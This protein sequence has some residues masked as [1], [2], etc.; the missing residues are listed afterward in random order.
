M[1]QQAETLIDNY[2]S[3]QDHLKA[4]IS[5]VCEAVSAKKKKSGKDTIW[6]FS[7]MPESRMTWYADETGGEIF[8]LDGDLDFQFDAKDEKVAASVVS[9]VVSAINK[10]GKRP[11]ADDEDKYDAYIDKLESLVSKVKGVS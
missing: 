11:S 7:G 6:N 10:A 1:G 3:E 2:L 4:L 5:T 8:L 9:A